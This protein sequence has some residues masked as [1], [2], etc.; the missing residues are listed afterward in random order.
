MWKTIAVVCGLGG[1]AWADGCPVAPDVTQDQTA[2]LEGLQAAPNYT[3][4]RGLTARLWELWLEAPDE[5]SQRMLDEGMAAQR[6]ANYEAA[7][8]RLNALVGYCPFYA[9]GYNQRAFVAYLRGDYLAALPD[10]DAALEINPGHVAALAG[11]A[12]TLMKLGREAEG[13]QALR[14]A[15]ALNPWLPERGLLTSPEGEDL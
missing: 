14:G 8:A 5:A 7:E 6:T 9:E 15:L 11:K 2:V 3:A 12:L 10:L 4:A 13:Q 1:A